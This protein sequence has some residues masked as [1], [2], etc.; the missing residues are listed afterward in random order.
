VAILVGRADCR[1]RPPEVVG[2]LG[3]PAGDGGVRQG[4]VE[5]G[6]EPGVLEKSIVAPEGDGGRDLVPV[7]GRGGRARAVIPEQRDLGLVGG[8]RGAVGGTEA[9]DLVKRGGVL[10][11]IEGGWARRSELGGVGQQEWGDLTPLG[12]E[13]PGEP[14]WRRSPS[15]V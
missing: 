7:A 12:I 8:A 5:H 2:E 14:W 13:R 11:A 1:D 15:A 10:G 6:E 9:L 3:V 4:R